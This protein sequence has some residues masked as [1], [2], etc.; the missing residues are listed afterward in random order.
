MGCQFGLSK[1]IFREKYFESLEVE[2]IEV[3]YSFALETHKSLYSSVSAHK[4]KTIFFN[5]LQ[6]NTSV[7]KLIDTYATLPLK[8]SVINKMSLFSRKTGIHVVLQFTKKWIKDLM[9]KYK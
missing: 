4:N 5:K 1:Y 9:G 3:D 8:I 7:I 6:Q 2:K